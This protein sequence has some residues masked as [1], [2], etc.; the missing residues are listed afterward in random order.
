MRIALAKRTEAISGL[1][2]R[3]GFKSL[4]F[5]VLFCLALFFLHKLVSFE[6]ITFGH[7][8]DLL[9][10]FYPYRAFDAESLKSFSIPLWNPY[11]FSGF[12]YLASLRC[13]IFYPINLVFLIL[14]TH[15]G[16]NFS[17]ILHIFLAG[18]FMYIFARSLSLDE[19]SSMVSALAL[20][21]SGF[22]IDKV[23][24]G[25]P[26][27]IES[28][29]WI[30]LIFLFFIKAVEKERLA[31]GILCG[32]LFG[33]QL[34]S[35]HPQLPYYGIMALSFLVI[36]FFVYYLKRVEYRKAS[37]SILGFLI[38]V[39]VGLA[40]TSIQLIPVAE[41]SKYSIRAF[42]TNQFDF[43]ARWSMEPSYLIT[44]VLPRLAPI[45]GTNTYPFPVSLGYIG[46]LPLLLAAISFFSIRDK[47]V[48]FFWILLL[49]SVLLVLGKYT[50]V[51]G[52]F[53]RFFPGFSTFR[54]PIF[55]VYLCIF[56]LSILSGFGLSCLRKNDLWEQGGKRLKIIA[57]LL[58]V[59][60]LL[61]ILVAS[62]TYSL[63]FV[64]SQA[65]GLLNSASVLRNNLKTLDQLLSKTQRFRGTLIYDFITTGF[66]LFLA[67][68]SIVFCRKLRRR[69]LILSSIIV[70]LVF[71]DLKLYGAD[72][73]YTYDLTPF[74]S[75]GKWVDFLEEERQPFRVLPI[76][77]Y[78]EQD[79]VLKLNKISSINGYGSLEILQD[80]VD[81]V[82][83]FQDK[84]VV[85]A[86]CIA[87]VANYDSKAV[88]MLNTKYVLTAKE[89]EDGQLKLVY[90]DDI[91]TAKTW[92]PHK[93]GTIKLRIYENE[94]VLPRAFIVHSVK[95]IED[96]RQILETL[97]DPQFDPRATVILE[98]NPQKTV[99]NSMLEGGTEQVSFVSYRGNEVILRVSLAENGFLFLSEVYYPD[100]KAFVDG[101]ER[102]IYRANYLFR[103]L[104][105][106]KGVHTIKFVFRPFSFR[107][108][109]LITL[110]T[111][112][113]LLVL[114]IH[115]AYRNMK[116]E[117]GEENL[118]QSPTS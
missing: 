73:I 19:F 55:L 91:P 92:E 24:W 62:I 38:T 118:E 105:L 1:M 33:V 50:P 48:L 93:K 35:G 43:F 40:L 2:E 83:A 96:R 61:L 14:P 45:I 65:T 11:T 26:V 18:C 30:P 28:C 102:R 36:Y 115:Y 68:I 29:V 7:A 85:Q 56:S 23:S 16:I 72:F 80:Y 32:L 5:I 41:L 111:L 76:L 63:P 97:R 107:I 110:I 106:D 116:K 46:V 74:V 84:P 37:I 94:A 117:Y 9:R 17:L 113:G 39:V 27:Y 90:S 21:F 78:P 52:F 57:G 87:R 51:Y 71:V 53:Y 98:E 31:Y 79:P 60:G 49:S 89:I 108:G 75:K 69:N 66:M 3:F 12:P 64:K 47:Y 34:F 6:F 20:M 114:L 8:E 4:P 10:L 82:A 59:L 77:D 100:W 42:S 81:F 44:F 22:F 109:A 104:Y 86:A 101:E 70:F 15:L 13:H 67:A 95:V 112:F 99:G 103:S 25:H 58:I 54:N 88:N